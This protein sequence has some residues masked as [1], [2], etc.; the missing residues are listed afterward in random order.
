[1]ATK[2]LGIKSHEVKKLEELIKLYEGSNKDIEVRIFKGSIQKEMKY[3]Q[4]IRPEIIKEVGNP[5]K[6]LLPEELK[7]NYKHKKIC[8]CN[9]N[10]TFNRR[11][12][13]VFH[14]LNHFNNPFD[15]GENNRIRWKKFR[16][17]DMHL[18]NSVLKESLKY[19][20]I[21][22]LNEYYANYKAVKQLLN[23]KK[24]KSTS[25]KK[26]EYKDLKENL[27]IYVQEFFQNIQ[28]KRVDHEQ[29]LEFMRKRLD[30]EYRNL[31]LF[32]GGWYGF[33]RNREIYNKWKD[34][35]LEINEECFL[36]REFLKSFRKN[37]RKKKFQKLKDNTYNLFKKHF[38]INYNYQF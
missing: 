7:D 21:N 24:F 4:R 2:F 30:G 9:Y 22:D 14:E 23:Y 3:D 5:G 32:M 35:L 10:N 17:L 13:L 20:I 16:N 36:S 27:L 37:L 38:E 29:N 15:I 33:G 26:G 18:Q 12:I 6:A 11:V 25:L 19:H 31:F 28:I 8:Y 1:M 34:Y